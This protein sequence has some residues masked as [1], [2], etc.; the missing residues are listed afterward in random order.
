MIRSTQ[1]TAAIS[2]VHLSLAP[3]DMSAECEDMCNQTLHRG[4]AVS[5]EYVCGVTKDI[6]KKYSPLL[7]ICGG[8]ILRKIR[9]NLGAGQNRRRYSCS[10]R[11]LEKSI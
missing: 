1:A 3:W 2:V 7:D 8:L 5:W 9:K 4:D 11:Y 6:C 10:S